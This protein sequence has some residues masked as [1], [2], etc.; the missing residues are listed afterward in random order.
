VLGVPPTPCQVPEHTVLSY[1]LGAELGADFLEVRRWLCSCA[2]VQLCSVRSL[3]WALWQPDLVSS[4]DGVL[5]VRH[6][7]LLD[8]STDVAQ[9]PEFA[10]LR[11]TKVCS[12][13]PEIGRRACVCGGVGAAVCA[14]MAV[15]VAVWLCGCVQRDQQ[16]VACS[17]LCSLLLQQLSFPW[18]HN[19]TGWFVED[20][21]WAEL[22]T[23][24]AVSR[25]GQGGGPLDRAYR[26]LSFTQ[27]LD[28]VA[29]LTQ[30]I[31]R[32]LGVYAMLSGL[33][34]FTGTGGI[35]IGCAHAAGTPKPSTRTIS[36]PLA[37][38]WKP[39]HC[40]RW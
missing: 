12:A 2:A 3:T 19:V 7:V 21:T 33:L 38:R 26:I 35:N 22:Q 4:K 16:G 15:C 24:Y 20:F 14:C 18:P 30:L 36:R 6:D 1:T 32:D 11:S 23:L 27:M 39:K 31:G 25:Q 9:H 17:H 5:V 34:L 40:R 8:E 37:C 28:L 10:H 13:D 29:N